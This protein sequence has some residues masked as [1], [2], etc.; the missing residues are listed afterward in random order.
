MKKK[1][2]DANR[3]WVQRKPTV[4]P[5]PATTEFERVVSEFKLTPD[6]YVRSARLRD[7]V[8]ENKDEK[9]VPEALLRAWNFRV[10]ARL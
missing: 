3:Q 6:E 7:W 8:H 9:Y 4:P 1:M 2:R 10:D 5:T